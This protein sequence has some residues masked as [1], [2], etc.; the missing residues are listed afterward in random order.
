MGWSS[1]R[2]PEGV[3]GKGHLGA[4]RSWTQGSGRK[5][6]A[7]PGPWTCVPAQAAA[8]LSPVG[9][10]AVPGCPQG[11]AHDGCSLD[12]PARLLLRCGPRRPR[13]SGSPVLRPHCGRPE[14]AW[15]RC[16]FRGRPPP[17][18]G[19]QHPPHF[20]TS[21]GRPGTPHLG[22]GW[23]WGRGLGS[24]GRGLGSGAGSAD[25]PPRGLSPR[26]VRPQ[27]SAATWRRGASLQAREGGAWDLWVPGQ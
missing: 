12:L 22:A 23:P 11:Q 27:R 18:A 25:F 13:S 21:P 4:H 9:P 14:E 3:E 24:G 26:Q 2:D 20:R 7:L 15:G 19:L 8:D 5:W 1:P 17:A 10:A 16:Q 6:G